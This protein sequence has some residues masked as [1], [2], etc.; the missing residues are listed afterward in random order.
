MQNR[1][2]PG[3]KRAAQA[4]LR[5]S[6]AVERLTRQGGPALLRLDQWVH[7][8]RRRYAHEDVVIVRW[9]DDF[10]MGF[11]P[12]PV[13]P[14]DEV[15]QHLIAAGTDTGGQAA[16]MTVAATWT[17]VGLFTG[18]HLP[19][20]GMRAGTGRRR[21]RAARRPGWRVAP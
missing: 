8:W 7:Q 12:G 16:V 11:E 10:I 15:T 13:W 17:L 20:G 14:P 4:G 5:Y 3:A 6:Q 21:A 18:R 9:A 1:R 19:R 2:R